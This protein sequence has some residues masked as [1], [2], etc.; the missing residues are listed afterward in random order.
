MLAGNV[1]ENVSEL[2][3]NQPRWLILLYSPPLIFQYGNHSMRNLR[4]IMGHITLKVYTV[5]VGVIIGQKSL[6]NDIVYMTVTCDSMSA[7]TAQN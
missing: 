5:I 7:I 3:I 6:E 1:S 4:G 2:S